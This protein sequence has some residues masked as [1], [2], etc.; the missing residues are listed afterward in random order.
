MAKTLAVLFLGMITLLAM[1]G[2]VDPP[3]KKKVIPGM[4]QGA[5]NLPWSRPESWQGGGNKLGL[6]SSY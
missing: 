4:Q 3:K 2:C 6:P 5:S 1:T